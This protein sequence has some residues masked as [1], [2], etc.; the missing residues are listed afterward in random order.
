MSTITPTR[1]RAAAAAA[2]LALAL[3]G[4]SAVGATPG[5]S[6]SASGGTVTLVTHDSFAVPDGVLADFTKATGLTVKVVQQ[7]DAGALVN[8]LVLTKDA[9]LGDAVFGIDNTFGSRALSQGV[10][11]AAP[12][13]SPALA[14]AKKHALAGDTTGALTAIDYGDV[15]L[16]VDHR[17]FAA[18]GL[19]EPVTLTDLTKPQY[20]D[21]LVVPNPVTSSPGFAFLLATIGAFGTDGWQGYWKALKANG[22]QVANGWT[23]AYETDFS[24]GGGNGSRPVVLSYSSSPPVTIPDGGTEPTTG[25]LLDTCFRQTEYAGVLTGAKNPTGAAQLVDFLLSDEVQASIPDQMY[26]YPVSTSVQLPAEWASFAPLADT[27]FDVPP[28]DIAAHRSDWL[29]QWS[30]LVVG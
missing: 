7:G 18:K 13:S 15:C 5:G 28:A 24:G 30:D 23:D 1:W 25:A 8:Q 9:P 27:P 11:T 4:C 29:Q 2:T 12:L 10:V 26:M 6:A 14:D 21:L 3:A 22:L 16:N 20:K 19:A 17:W